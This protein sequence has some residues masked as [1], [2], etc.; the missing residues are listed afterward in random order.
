MIA[1]V[2]MN[3]EGEWWRIKYKMKQ[4]SLINIGNIGYISP[5]KA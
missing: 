4:L 1:K 2:G 3:D 5:W